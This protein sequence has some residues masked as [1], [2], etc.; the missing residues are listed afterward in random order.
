MKRLKISFLAVVA[1]ATICL[2]SFT[3]S[4]EL[5][6]RSGSQCSSTNGY[7]AI[8]VSIPGPQVLNFPSNGC[9]QTKEYCAQLI[10][11]T[12][13]TGNPISCDDVTDVFCCAE[14]T[15][16]SECETA[17][18]NFPYKLVVHCKTRPTP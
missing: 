11:G 17:D 9:P 1:I 12:Q 6:K 7:S 13:I 15:P 14:L 5:K 8:Q 3:K 10:S 2:T 18:S 16:D 4:G